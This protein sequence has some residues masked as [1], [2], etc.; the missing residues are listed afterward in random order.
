MR[1]FV[2]HIC[3]YCFTC[4]LLVP[5]FSITHLSFILPSPARDSAGGDP[6]DQARSGGQDVRGGKFSPFYWFT[7]CSGPQKLISHSSAYICSCAKTIIK[8][9]PRF[10]CKCLLTPFYLGAFCDPALCLFQIHERP[11]RDGESEENVFQSDVMAEI[12]NKME[13]RVENW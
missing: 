1:I 8:G 10:D 3:C 11:H 12:V 4:K 2:S 7:N 9:D 5:Y 13:C 6:E